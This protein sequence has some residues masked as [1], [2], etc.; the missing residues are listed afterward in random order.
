MPTSLMGEEEVKF[1]K[2]KQVVGMSG[3]GAISW[4]GTRVW[5][6]WTMRE[7]IFS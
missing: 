6:R 7:N 3:S 1:E 2:E 4:N 5:K